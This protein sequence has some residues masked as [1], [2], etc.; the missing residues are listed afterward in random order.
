MDDKNSKSNMTSFFLIGNFKETFFLNNQD[1]YGVY[2]PP[3]KTKDNKDNKEEGSYYTKKEKIKNEIINNHLEGKI[4][5]GSIPISRENKAK[6]G[7]IDIDNYN[8]TY[9]NN[10]IDLIYR[11]NMPL[12]PFQSKSGG[13]HLY[14]FFVQEIEAKKVKEYLKKFITILELSNDTEIFPKQDFLEETGSFIN[15]P[16]FGENRQLIK[17]DYKNYSIVEAFDI[18]KN[19]KVTIDELDLFFNN[20]P[21]F[22]APPCLQ[23]IYLRNDTQF[24]NNYLFSLGVYYKSKHGDDF[25]KYLT[26]ANNRLKNPIAIDELSKT[27]INTH[28]KKD[29][30]YKCNDSPLNDL[31]NKTECNN[32]QFGIGSSNISKLSFGQL[33]QYLSDPP[34][35]EWI[36]NDKILRFNNENEIIK[37]DKFIVLCFRLLKIMPCKLIYKKW[38]KIINTALNNMVEVKIDEA[39]DISIGNTFMTW[40]YYFFEQTAEAKNKTQILIGKPYKDQELKSYIFKPTDL[41]TFLETRNFRAYT[42]NDIR[43]KLKD[44]GGESTRYYIPENKATTR[45]WKLPFEALEK[46]GDNPEVPL[47]DFKEEDIFSGEEY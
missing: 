15:L 17:K 47:I 44:I 9:T 34:Y 45:A 20:I 7:I 41:F 11:Y 13:L 43:Y 22:D 37:Q 29:Y 18:I 16:F 2:T 5:V 42:T 36:V 21:L 1:C 39:D 4:G 23:A 38:A 6:F 19:R 24:R 27:I 33:T 25:E 3:Q 35:Y 30:S 26:E 12:L 40:L 31:C 14:L 32:R 8:D 10:V 46:F 28:N